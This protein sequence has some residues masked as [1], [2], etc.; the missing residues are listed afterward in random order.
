MNLNLPVINH[1][2]SEKS[3]LYPFSWLVDN[4]KSNA[5]CRKRPR[6]CVGP[7]GDKATLADRN[8]YLSQ[9]NGT[10]RVA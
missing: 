9:M 3:F 10:C 4:L 5:L 8:L 1:T 2:V 6:P 7:E